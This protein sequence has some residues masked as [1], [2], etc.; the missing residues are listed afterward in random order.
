MC[1]LSNKYCWFIF[2]CVVFVE[3][4]H[5]DANGFSDIFINCNQAMKN[6]TTKVMVPGTWNVRQ[7]PAQFSLHCSMRNQYVKSFCNP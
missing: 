3:A 5:L 4:E 6:A 1:Q 7:I 2:K